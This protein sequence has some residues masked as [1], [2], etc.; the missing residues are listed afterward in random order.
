MAKKNINEA[1][2]K[3][4]QKFSNE[5]Q[6]ICDQTNNQ[7]IERLNDHM[8][9]IVETTQKDVKQVLKDNPKISQNELIE[10]ISDKS[11]DTT[12][13]FDL[14]NFK[15]QLAKIT[16][17][18]ENNKDIV[19]GVKN[20]AQNVS[21]KISDKFTEGLARVPKKVSK[22]SKKA[23]TNRPAATKNVQQSKTNPKPKR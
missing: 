4:L 15:T 23:N 11:N 2:E 18:I 17:A 13:T 5:L 9:H 16:F 8:K 7:A 14:E 1:L 12:L 3:R 19:K 10:L 20:E 21:G 22:S 6:E